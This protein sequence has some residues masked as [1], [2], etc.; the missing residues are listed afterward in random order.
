[1]VIAE[2]RLTPVAAIHDMVYGTRMSNAKL[3]SHAAFFDPFDR[4]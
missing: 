3:S 2:D 1:M 4:F